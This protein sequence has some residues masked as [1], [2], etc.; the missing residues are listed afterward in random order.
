[1]KDENKTHWK[2]AFN[3]NYLGASDLPGYQDIIV[4]IKE[5]KLEMAVGTKEEEKKN[6]AHFKE[7]IK[8][9][10][11]NVENSKTVRA[12]AGGSNYLE[13][14][15]DVKV[16]IYVKEGIK[17]FGAVTDALRIRNFHPKQKQD[18]TPILDKLNACKT[19]TELQE[20]YLG[21]EKSHKTHTEVLALKEKLKA[22]LK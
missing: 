10:I 6:I 8:P 16:Q 22:E 21:L 14:W 19:L 20:A 15:T 11:L 4:T 17:A 2:K 9:M 12:L 13:D 7:K 1:M 5:V 3:S 18:I